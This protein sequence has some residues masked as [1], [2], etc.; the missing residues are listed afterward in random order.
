VQV[1]FSRIQ[2]YWRSTEHKSEWLNRP[3]DG[4]VKT[5]LLVFTTLFTTLFCFLLRY[6]LRCGRRQRMT[7]MFFGTFQTASRSYGG[8]MCRF[9]SAIQ[10][11]TI[12][13]FTTSA[14]MTPPGI[15]GIP[16][17][18]PD[19][20]SGISCLRIWAVILL[21]HNYLKRR[22]PDVHQSFWCWENCVSAISRLVRLRLRVIKGTHCNLPRPRITQSQKV[23]L[24][25]CTENY[26]R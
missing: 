8:Y 6:L 2:P 11:D 17:Q 22:V 14:D 21:R 7:F 5:R 10:L 15:P 18:I 20:C 23:C 19:S 24:L 13:C 9:F 26:Q 3:G 25:F 16:N 4:L 1:F 12:G